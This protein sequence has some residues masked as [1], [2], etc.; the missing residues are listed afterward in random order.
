[1][2]YAL[3]RG[4]STVAFRHE[5]SCYTARADRFS[6][7]VNA[8]GAT[9]RFHLRPPEIEQV[10]PEIQLAQDRL[11]GIHI[12]DDQ[13][14]SRV[15]AAYQARRFDL[16]HVT[17]EISARRLALSFWARMEAFGDSTLRLNELRPI[18]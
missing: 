2:R 10:S 13:I 11:L 17:L 9:F 15:F 14:H 6:L 4:A 3:R 1:V 7:E 5:L 16:D 18:L 12:I 8:D